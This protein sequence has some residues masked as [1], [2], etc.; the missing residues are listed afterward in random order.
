MAWEKILMRSSHGRSRKRGKEVKM[1]VVV[2]KHIFEICVVPN[3]GVG[4]KCCVVKEKVQVETQ[5][6][7]K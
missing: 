1:V 3:E 4:E 7:Q 6:V 2:A 5:N